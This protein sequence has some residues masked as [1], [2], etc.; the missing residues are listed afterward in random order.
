MDKEVANAVLTMAYD[1][2]FRWSLFTFVAAA[3][4]GWLQTIC[5]WM[6]IKDNRERIEA[7]EEKNDNSTGSITGDDRSVQEEESELW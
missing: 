3:M 4:L 6:L 2:A 7:L 1:Y 5:L